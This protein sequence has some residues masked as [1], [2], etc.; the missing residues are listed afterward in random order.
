MEEGLG[1]RCIGTRKSYF[2]GE[3]VERP[4]LNRTQEFRKEAK[5]HWISTRDRGSIRD[6]TSRVRVKRPLGNDSRESIRRTRLRRG[7]VSKKR[8]GRGRD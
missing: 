6:M 2:R 7:R 3:G 5:E 1:I 8:E 4:S